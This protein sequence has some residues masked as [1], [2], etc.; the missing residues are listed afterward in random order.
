MFGHQKKLDW[1]DGTMTFAIPPSIYPVRLCLAGFM[2]VD[3]L[4]S[5][6]FCLHTGTLLA[7]KAKN[8]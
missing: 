6:S 8:P 3:L 4:F 2:T 7:R 5:W 1:C